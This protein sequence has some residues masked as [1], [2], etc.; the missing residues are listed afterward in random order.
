M[1]PNPT[2]AWWPESLEVADATVNLEHLDT[3]LIEFLA[4]AAA[5][6]WGAYGKPLVVT[7]GNDGKHAAGSKHFSWKAV[8]LRS[9]DT[10]IA[11][12]QDFAH[13]LSDVQQRYEVGVF[14]E[15][16]IGAP[17]WHVEVA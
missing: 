13:F 2:P 15:R 16:F 8:D 4:G 3:K 1:I 7:S 11:E 5:R 10:S 14:D 17:H 6:H 9:R 12:Q